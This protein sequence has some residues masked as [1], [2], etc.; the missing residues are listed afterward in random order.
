MEDLLK[1][2]ESEKNNRFKKKWSKLEKGDKLNRLQLFI[3]EQSEANELDEKQKASLEK[4]LSNAFQKNNISKNSEIEYCVD[5]AKILSITNLE[6]DEEKKEY[7]IKIQKKI[8]KTPSSKSK[9]NID[10]HFSRSKGNK[11]KK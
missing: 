9:S 4:L 3:E 2:I 8:T 11:D 6:Y 5:S 10:R 7:S 1:V